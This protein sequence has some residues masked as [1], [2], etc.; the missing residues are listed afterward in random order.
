MATVREYFPLLPQEP[1]KPR[2]RMKKQ[3]GWLIRWRN[4]KGKWRTR[5]FRGDKRNADKLLRGI[6]YEVEQI[7]SGLKQAPERSMSLAKAVSMYLSHLGQLLNTPGAQS[8]AMKRPIRYSKDSCP[9]ISNCKPSSAVTSSVS[10]ANG[11]RLAQQP[12]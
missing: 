4:E 7:A 8:G 5:I 12:G 10:R 6:V 3:D 9:R 1:G 2:E 11:S